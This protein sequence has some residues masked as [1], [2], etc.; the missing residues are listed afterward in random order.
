MCTRLMSLVGALALCA[1]C[2]RLPVWSGEVDVTPLE[3]ESIAKCGRGELT[4]AGKQRVTRTPYIQ[5][6]TLTSTMVA[7]GS[8]DGLAEVVVREPGGVA[9]AIGAGSVRALPPATIW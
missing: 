2:H 3:R 9:V 8:R 5:G 1:G 4:P 7:W 6:T